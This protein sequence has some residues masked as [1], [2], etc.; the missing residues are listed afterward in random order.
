VG[1]ALWAL[2]GAAGLFVLFAL[3]RRFLR[4]RR[5]AATTPE[6]TPTDG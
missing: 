3:G 6:E 2:M 1:V 5:A 4:G